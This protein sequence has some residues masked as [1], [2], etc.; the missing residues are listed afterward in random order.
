MKTLYIILTVLN[1]I[2]CNC[3][4]GNFVYFSRSEKLSSNWN[5]NIETNYNYIQAL[6]QNGLTIYETGR[7][8]TL[9]NVDIKEAY[10]KLPGICNLL[11]SGQD[12]TFETEFTFNF[13]LYPLCIPLFYLS[14]DN[15]NKFINNE[16]IIQSNYQNYE[17]TMKRQHYQLKIFGIG[18]VLDLSIKR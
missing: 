14:F 5:T 2:T 1:K 16:W 18:T 10:C 6:D 15:C 8:N 3:G 4:A 12:N 11:I 9:S 17:R 7:F 13:K